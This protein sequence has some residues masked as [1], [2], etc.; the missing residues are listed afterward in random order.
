MTVE[1]HRFVEFS[2]AQPPQLL[3]DGRAES[4][5]FIQGCGELSSEPRDLFVARFV[6]LLGFGEA[7][8]TT[9]GEC[10]VRLADLIEGHRLAEA[11]DVF[12]LAFGGFASTP[13]AE[14]V[15]DLLDVLVGKRTLGA[16]DHVAE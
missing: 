1:H 6:V 7:D 11:R 14:R 13:G 2:L 15:C 9:W 16:V 8:V 5:R 12:V 10:V 3:T 4:G